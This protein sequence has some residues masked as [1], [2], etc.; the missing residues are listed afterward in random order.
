MSNLTA[1][2]PVKIDSEQRR[3]NID[4]TLRYLLQNTNCKIIIT[5]CDDSP[6]LDTNLYKNNRLKYFFEKL[7]NNF[8]HRTRLINQMLDIVDTPVVA[9]YDADVLLPTDSYKTC[10]KLILSNSADVIYPYGFNTFG[11]R[12][13][14][15][16]TKGLEKFYKT[17][18]LQDLEL[19]NRSVWLSRF[20]HVQ[21]FKTEYYIKGFMENE[22]YKHWCPEDD[23]RGIR[24]KKL[25]YKVIW[26]NSVVFHQEHPPSN[27]QQPSNLEEILKLHN[28]LIALN[29]DD[30]ISY[31]K[32]QSYLQKYNS[33]KKLCTV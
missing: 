23:E 27:Q 26:L 20:G 6:K 18:N 25:N 12:R 30:L 16:D 19:D 10:E 3:I 31:Y 13:I 15:S 14:F 33:Y 22:N 28:T 29:K 8:F 32:N 21:F 1:I 11:Q 7:E 2:I 17:L 4:T 24:F 5:E 9:N